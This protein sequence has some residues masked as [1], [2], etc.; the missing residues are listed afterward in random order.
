V[1]VYPDWRDRPLAGD[2]WA[3]CPMG[4]GAVPS[5]HEPGWETP[6]WPPG[7]HQR[8]LPYGL[9]RTGY[10]EAAHTPGAVCIGSR[11]LGLVLPLA[12][13]SE[14]ELSAAWAKLDAACPAADAVLRSH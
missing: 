11:S 3:A 14:A 9:A 6:A 12:A 5:G 1:S 8:W 2:G 10:H 13:P 7:E 4:C